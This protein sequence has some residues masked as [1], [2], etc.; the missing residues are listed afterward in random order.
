MKFNSIKILFLVIPLILFCGKKSTDNDDSNGNTADVVNV[1]VKVYENGQ[2][3][4]DIFVVIEAMIQLSTYGLQD[5]S[6]WETTSYTTTQAFEDLTNNYGIAEFRF[7]NQSVPDRGGIVISKVTIK[8]GFE[9]ILEDTEE[10]F[11]RKNNNL[12]IEYTL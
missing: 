11:V 6:D 2:P 10:K 1:S 3:A 4:A 7:E 12:D 8:R 5:G 9:V